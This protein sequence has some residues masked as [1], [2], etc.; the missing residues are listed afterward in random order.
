VNRTTIINNLADQISAKSYLEI[1]VRLH[2]ENFDKVNIK[3]KVSV[4]PCYEIFDREPTFKLTS[5]D[6]FIKNAET[7]DVIFIDGLHEAKQ[8]ERDILNS[9]DVL[10]RGGYIV[11]HDM[12]PVVYERQLLFQDPKRR[13]YESQEKQKGNPAYG[14]WNGDC[15]KAW[16]KIR[17]QR[18]DLKMFV[19]DTDFGVGVI[20]RGSQDLLKTKT[21]NFTYS[22]LEEHRKEWLNLVSVEEFF[23]LL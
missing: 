23:R 1:G 6:F 11:C 19:V 21:E 15:W 12:N 14:L 18:Q 4:D 3:H 16:V 22:N 13:E 10:N 9:L 7:F 5:D 8:V 17:T 20:S 2:T